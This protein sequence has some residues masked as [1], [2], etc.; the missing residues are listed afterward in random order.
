VSIKGA[1]ASL[2][3][4]LLPSVGI[5]A[6]LGPKLILAYGFNG[7]LMSGASAEWALAVPMEEDALLLGMSVGMLSALNGGNSTGQQALA[8]QLRSFPTLLQACYQWRL[9]KPFSLMGGIRSG[10]IFA[11]PVIEVGGASQDSPLLATLAAGA[12]IGLGVD[13]A[14]DT[15]VLELAADYGIPLMDDAD[16]GQ[17]GTI[18]L[19]LGYRFGL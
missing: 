3:I 4:T 16:V 10:V 11:A 5:E 13:I 12:Q 19:G 7:R 8:R 1:Q 15:L 2:P 17:L 6:R 18:S 14:R 9:F